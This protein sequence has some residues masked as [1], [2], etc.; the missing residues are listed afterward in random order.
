[1][2]VHYHFRAEIV[3]VT[4]SENPANNEGDASSRS[5]AKKRNVLLDDVEYWNHRKVREFLLK[6]NLLSL[7]PI[8]DGMNGEELFILYT[9][10]K[11]NSTSM[12]RSMKFELLHAYHRILPIS[13]YLRFMSHM[14]AICDDELPTTLDIVRQTRNHDFSDSE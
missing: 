12:F 14:R 7:I 13:T 8:C 4:T 3:V 6:N 9:M 11:A 5:R 10:C 2:S 1:M